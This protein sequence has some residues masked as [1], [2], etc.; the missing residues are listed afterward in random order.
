MTSSKSVSCYVEVKYD[1]ALNWH[2]HTQYVVTF[3]CQTLEFF[4]NFQCQG[5]TFV[6]KVVGYIIDK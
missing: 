2:T 4:G 1:D 3:I 6:Y 5:K